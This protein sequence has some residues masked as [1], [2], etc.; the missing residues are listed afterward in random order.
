VTYGLEGSIFSAGV[1]VKWLRDTL[2]LIQNAAETETLAKSV[3][4]T[5]GV[6]LV[7][8]FT[9]LGA[10]YWNPDARGALLGLTRNTQRAHIV[11]A[12]LEAVAYQTHDLV[13]AMQKDA[14][15][16]IE[17]IRVDGGMTPNGWLMQFLADTLGVSVERPRCVETTA[18][19]AAFL[20]GLQAGL[21]SSL[22]DIEL[23]WHSDAIF[24][25]HIDDALRRVRYQGWNQAIHRVLMK[26]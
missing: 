14:N 8:A 1:T 2:Q 10:P 5:G 23:C 3:P 18:L 20:A 21:Y 25:P 15:E 26:E 17:H 16:S 6:Y 19:G 12:S 9:G 4:D 13:T 22:K 11:R 7:P 24:T